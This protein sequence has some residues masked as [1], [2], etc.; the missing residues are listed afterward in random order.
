MFDFKQ[1]CNDIQV[2]KTHDDFSKYLESNFMVLETY[3]NTQSLSQLD[4]LKF[5]LE[6]MLYDLLDKG[7]IQKSNTKM[8]NAFLILM[9]ELMES[10]NLR[11]AITIIL[12]YLPEISIK[13]RLEASLLYLKIND[14][15]K[16]YHSRFDSI[17]ALLDKSHTDQD[18][19]YKVLYA[20]L[21]YYLKAM[22]EF[23][24]VNQSVLAE[25]FRQLF[26]TNQT[27]YPFLNN[28]FIKGIISRDTSDFH[29]LEEEV[30]RELITK[31]FQS[32]SCAIIDSTQSITAEK[33]DYSQKL[34]ALNN[35]NFQTIKQVSSDY[36][37]RI[38]NPDALH[39]RLLRGQAII[40]DEQLLYKYMA[41]FGAMH[42]AKLYDAFDVLLP[43][44]NNQT[45]NIVD[46]GCGQAFATMQLIAYIKDHH[47]SINI[48]QINLIEPS[49]LALKRGM[50]HV[51]VLK[52]K[53]YKIVPINKTIDCLEKSDLAFDDPYMVVHLLSNILDVE[54]FSLDTQLLQKISLN[55]QQ[56]NYFLCVGPNRDDKRNSRTDLFYKYFDDNFDTELLSTRDSYIEKYSRYEKIFKVS[57]TKSEDISKSK[58]EI[59]EYHVDIYTKLENFSDIISPI[60][61]T[62]RLKETIESDPD[63]VI[64]K[65]RKMA[66]IIT[67]KIYSQFE[68][69]E[70]K[71]S[72]NDKIRYLSFEKKVFN[73]KVQSYFHTIR[74]LGNVS[75][76][77]DVENPITILKEDAYFLATA[78]ALV[79]E[80]LKKSKLI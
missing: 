34:Y 36:I 38:G 52:A 59:Q 30:R 23:K 74:T 9:A 32:T 7:L 66:E 49:I 46:W 61:D 63:Y 42:K 51:D 6:E 43:Q 1:L 70:S 27:K 3:F 5:D 39:E 78:L 8:I 18:H 37:A 40:D 57:A 75:I 20:A 64:Y 68:S 31:P 24:R 41:A 71:V 22:N 79:I 29:L 67:S 28:P 25:S 50:L 80:E 48:H 56:N 54:S 62:K 73:R 17:M 77:E 16:D 47:L 60:L 44:L 11:G 53:E 10:A 2:L 55:I 13:Y 14:L 4:A 69:N 76:H 15:S 19:G 72:Q 35:P 12:N 33:S 65:I 58:H 45:I 21:N 26:K